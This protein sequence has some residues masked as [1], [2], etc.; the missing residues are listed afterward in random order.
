VNGVNFPDAH[1]TVE[2]LGDAATYN[3]AI[4][5]ALTVLKRTGGLSAAV[6]GL[7]LTASKDLR[8]GS[9]VKVDIAQ[10]ATGR[11][12]TFGSAGSTIVAPVLTGV[13][14]DR[15][16]ITLTWDGAAFVADSV[17]QKIVDAA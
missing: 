9:K 11:N 5:D 3:V 16:V 8:I 13:A 4:S 1:A 17:W 12:V 10:G 6:T 2:T 15:D 14:L 7:S